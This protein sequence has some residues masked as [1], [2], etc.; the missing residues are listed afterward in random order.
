MSSVA[1]P[2]KQLRGFTKV[3]LDP[4]QVKTCT[5]KLTSDDLSLLD[6]NL[7]RVVEPGTFRVMVGALVP[8]IR[9]TG[10]LLVR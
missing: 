9:Q 6:A 2:V 1:T 10:E 8:G 4:G 5:F 3:E 7:K